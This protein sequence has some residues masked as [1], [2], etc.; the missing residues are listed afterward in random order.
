VR[1]VRGPDAQKRGII[2]TSN[3]HKEAFHGSQ[4]V[5]RSFGVMKKGVRHDG[6]LLIFW[7]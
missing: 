7:E 2:T 5:V 6:R 3:G 1:I 4:E